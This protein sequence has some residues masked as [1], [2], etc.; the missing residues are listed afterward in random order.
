MLIVFVLPVFVLLL[1]LHVHELEKKI[2]SKVF[3][4]G[5]VSQ[6]AQ[7]SVIFI[8]RILLI[9]LDLFRDIDRMSV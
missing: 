5:R 8:A 3:F 9:G 2:A 6:V 7:K 1:V 4:V